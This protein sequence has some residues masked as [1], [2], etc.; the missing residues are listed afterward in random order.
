MDIEPGHGGRTSRQERS[1][2]RSMLLGMY[3][4]GERIMTDAA[5]QL[6]EMHIH[7]AA[8][9]DLR[10]ENA[11]M[12]RQLADVARDSSASDAVLDIVARKR[13]GSTSKGRWHTS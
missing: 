11:F 10:A 2:M 12:L 7:A 8:P 9:G 1:E 13:P 5:R 4:A 6:K 3:E